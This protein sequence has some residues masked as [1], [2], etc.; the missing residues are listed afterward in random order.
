MIGREFFDILNS[1]YTFAILVAI[2]VSIWIL[3]AKID[4]R[5]KSEKR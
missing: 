1:A 2:F 5:S 4:K 3:I